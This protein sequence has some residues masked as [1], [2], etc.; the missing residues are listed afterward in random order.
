MN[1]DPIE[2]PPAFAARANRG[3]EWADWLAVLPAL[4][5]DLL[6][7]WDLTPDGPPTHGECALVLPVRTEGHRAAAL[8]ITWPHWEARTEHIALQRWHGRGAVELLRADPHR[9]ALLLERLEARDLTTIPVDDSCMVIAGLY[10]RLHVP[11]PPQLRRL[12][13]CTRD[14][15][16]RL[17]ALP[18]SA[19]VPHRLVDRGVGLSRELAQDGATDGTLVHTDLHPFNVLAARRE[20]WLAIDPKPLSGDPHY[21]IAPVL[22]NRWTEAVATGDLRGALR[23]RLALVCDVAG[24]DRDRARDWVVVRMMANALWEIEGSAARPGGPARADTELATRAIA[25]VKAV[26]D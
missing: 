12:S 8:K 21:E 16:E 23:R 10:R 22:W 20:P 13:E 9:L 4:A 5:S 14:W 11:A 3:A 26:H 24:L 1:A 17:A 18:R 25:V 19:P 7:D 2:I 15:A 6:T